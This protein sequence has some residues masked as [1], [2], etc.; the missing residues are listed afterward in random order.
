MSYVVAY[1]FFK[2]LPLSRCFITHPIESV[3]LLFATPIK[4]SYDYY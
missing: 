4:L 2:F 1:E 3:A